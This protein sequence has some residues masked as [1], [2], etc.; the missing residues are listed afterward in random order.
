[1]EK[2]TSPQY[3]QAWVRS[4][5]G[6]YTTSRVEEEHANYVVDIKHNESDGVE[7]RNPENDYSYVPLSLLPEDAIL[8]NVLEEAA[9][10][11]CIP[12]SEIV[13]TAL[14]SQIAELSQTLRTTL[15]Y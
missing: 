9:K 14:F 6:R 12:V 10:E 2:A 5:G 4:E 3:V 8:A 13:S 1:M 15:Q 11:C 7:G